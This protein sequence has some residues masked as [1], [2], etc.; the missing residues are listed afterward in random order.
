MQREFIVQQ[1]FLLWL[2]LRF[3]V[4]HIE[5]LPKDSFLIVR[6][7]SGVAASASMGGAGLF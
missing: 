6:F 7:Y 5:L 2:L 3:V 4:C 1:G